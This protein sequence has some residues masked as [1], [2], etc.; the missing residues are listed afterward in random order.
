MD[1][2]GAGIITHATAAERESGIAQRPGID[3]RDANIDRVRLHMQ[4]VFCDARGARAEEFIAPGGTVAADDIDF[5]ARMTDG[6]REIGKNV[7]D[8]MIVVLDVTGAMIAKEMV[9]LFFG[10]GKI[11][12]AAAVNDVDAFAG[13]R[14]IEA[15]MVF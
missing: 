8:A 10:L 4:A 2:A 12:I 9:E 7:E 6:G 11:E 3:S 5:P 13:V 14:M 1:E 15:K